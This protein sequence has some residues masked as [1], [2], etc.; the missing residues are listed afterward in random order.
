MWVGILRIRNVKRLIFLLILLGLSYEDVSFKSREDGLNIK[1]WLIKAPDNKKTV[2]FAHGYRKNR[3]QS[4][5]PIL[6]IAHALVNK[7]YN[8]LM[9]DFRN[10]GESE[11]NLTSVGQYEV[12]DLLG[13]VDFIK[14]RPELN[15]KIV[16]FGF[17][18]G[19]A[20]S[21]LAGAQE[22][23]VVA[24][25]ADSPF[26]DLKNYLVENLSVWTNL[27]SIPFNQSFLIVVPH[28]T[29]LKAETVSPVKEVNDLNGRPLLLIHGEADTDIPIKNSELL[30]KAYPKARFLRVPG[31]KHVKAFATAGRATSKSNLTKA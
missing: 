7:G 3:L 12:R 6:S 30:Q 5:V 1:G 19:A 2:I 10:C 9:F 31:A 20:T 21:I 28:L 22:P 23:A 29:G 8:V 25:I 17:S 13:A 26:A 27:P 14:S 15:Q 16:L 24:V 11:G 18:M 4:D